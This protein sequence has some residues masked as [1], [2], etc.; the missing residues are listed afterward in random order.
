MRH[1]FS[2]IK[3]NIEMYRFTL[4]DSKERAQKFM[5]QIS[6]QVAQFERDSINTHQHNQQSHT[7]SHNP[8]F[9]PRR[10]KHNGP[11]SYPCKYYHGPR[12]CGGGDNCQFIHEEQY[13]GM[14]IP[15]SEMDR[16]IHNQMEAYK[17]SIK[18]VQQQI[19]QQFK[20]NQTPMKA[21]HQVPTMQP[22]PPPP[23]AP[24]MF[25]QHIQQSINQQLFRSQHIGQPN[26]LFQNM[27]L[28]PL[29]FA[30]PQPQNNFPQLTPEEHDKI[31]QQLEELHKQS[32][33]NRLKQQENT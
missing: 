16:V 14:R 28:N 12:G 8:N 11:K 32:I 1:D 30:I 20:V 23:P 22:I 33:A 5:K 4:L 27:T 19:D 2:Q 6:S 29:L 24:T 3:S 18:G 26:F 25:P 21:P 9:N 17:N 31:K 13:K 10:F 15:Y 7:Y